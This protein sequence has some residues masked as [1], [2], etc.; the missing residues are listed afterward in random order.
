MVW[1][2]CECGNLLLGRA[3]EFDPLSSIYHCFAFIAQTVGLNANYIILINKLPNA[4]IFS[5]RC[6]FFWSSFVITT[7]LSVSVQM[8]DPL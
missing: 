5:D 8:T 3:F 7:L 1:K 2:C 4:N 6:R